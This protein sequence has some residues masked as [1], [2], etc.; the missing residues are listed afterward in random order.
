MA[1][2]SALHLT[3]GHL[4]RHVQESGVGSLLV[5][6]I[7]PDWTARLGPAVNDSRAV[8]PGG[9]FV[10]LQGEHTDGHRFIP[11]ALARGASALIVATLPAE[12]PVKE[13]GVVTENRQQPLSAIPAGSAALPIGRPVSSPVFWLTPDPLRALQNLAAWWR[14]QFPR[15]PVIG[16]TGSV[17]KTTAKDVLAAALGALMPALANPRSFNNEIGLPLTLLSLHGAHG[18]AIL[19]MGIYDVGDIAFLSGIARQTIGVVLNVDAVHLERA[20]SIERIA[21]AKAEIVE[22]LPPVGIAVLNHDDPR[23]RVMAAV[24]PGRVLTFGL[25][26]GADW[27]GVDLQPLADGLVL[28][29]LRGGQRY[30]LRSNLPGRHHAYALLAAAAVM[31]ALGFAPDEIIRA[32]EAVPAHLARQRVLRCAGDLLVIDDTYNASPLSV[33]AALDVLAAQPALRRIAILADMLELGPLAEESHR[34]IGARA[35]EVADLVLAVGSLAR[36]TAE[37]AGSHARHFEHK[38]A[39]RAALPDLLRAGDVLLVKGSRGMAMEEVVG[40]LCPLS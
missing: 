7:E 9:L 4:R 37:A 20:G 13:A 15:L 11:D 3:L 34:R 32:L 1:H 8:V 2:D 35:G 23:V 17:G 19:E 26:A 25:D 22:T 14:R 28:T 5:P 38:A 24:A 31:D 29:L 36:Y 40:W 30:P 6:G 39:L 27:R 10:A 33:L 12:L 21:Q 16:V 18:A